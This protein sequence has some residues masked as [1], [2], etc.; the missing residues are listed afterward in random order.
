MRQG[1][2]LIE[3]LI[4]E[5]PSE[6]LENI[7]KWFFLEMRTRPDHWKLMTDLTMKIERFQFVHDLATKKMNEYVFFIQG[8]LEQL[9]FE[10]PKEEARILAALFDGIGFQYL[11]VRNDYPLQEMEHYL[12]N[13]YCS[14]RN[15]Q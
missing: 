5:D 6:T 12:I 9:G 4:V 3:Q 14:K 10:N 11:V 13:K 8:M 2:E 15:K 1:E 7:F